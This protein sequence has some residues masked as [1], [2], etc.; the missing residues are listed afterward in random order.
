LQAFQTLGGTLGQAF[1]K[2]AGAGRMIVRKA[3]LA[4]AKLPAEPFGS[5]GF[6]KS[7]AKES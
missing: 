5:S 7:K 3:G 1:G 4:F 6:V 2:A